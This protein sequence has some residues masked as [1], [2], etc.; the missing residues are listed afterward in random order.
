[1]S[2]HC[3]STAPFTLDTM[4]P[5]TRVMWSFLSFL[6]FHHLQLQVNYPQNR[7]S[8]SPLLPNCINRLR[9][10]LNRPTEYYTSSLLLCVTT[11]NT[12]SVTISVIDGSLDPPALERPAFLHRNFIARWT[13]DV[14][15]VQSTGASVSTMATIIDE[16]RVMV[17]YESVMTRF[18]RLALRQW[19]WKVPLSLCSS[20]RRFCSRGRT[21]HDKR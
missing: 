7:I 4:L 19:L 5:R 3:I 18:R 11:G 16:N 1:M 10:H 20:T 12:P 14:S 6:I 9:P 15:D 21:P 13:A 17:G 2:S 8:P